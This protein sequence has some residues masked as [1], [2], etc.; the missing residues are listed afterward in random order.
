MPGSWRSLAL[1]V[2]LSVSVG[3][4]ISCSKDPLRA[5]RNRPPQTFLVAAPV[6]TSVAVLK[7]SYRVHLYWRGEDPDGFVVG[8]LYS[9]D[10]SS[11]GAF[12]FTTKTDSIF[13]LEVNDSTQIGGGTGTNPSNSRFHTFFIRAVDNL[14]KPDPQATIFNSRLF[15]AETT[16]PIVT[17]VGPITPHPHFPNDPVTIDT[18]CEGTPFQICWRGRDP[19]GVVTRYRFDVGSFSSTLST[20]SC[21]TFNDPNTPGSVQLSSGRYTMTVSAVDNANA[22]GKASVPVVVNRDPETWF[23]DKGAPIGHYIQ[24]HLKGQQTMIVGTFAP[25]DTVPFRSTVWWEWEGEDTG[26]GCEKNCLSGWSFR[27]LPGTRDGGEPYLIGFLDV[28]SAGPPLIRFNNNDPNQ[29]SQ[30][31]FANLILDSLDAGINL[32]A[33]VASRDC[34]GRADGTPAFFEFHCNFRPQL[35]SLRVTPITADVGQGLEPC[36]LIEWFGEDFE[37]G[38]TKGA[39]VRLDATRDLTFEDYEQSTIVADRVF[40]T[41]SPSGPH[42]VIVR[43]IDRAL[44]QSENRLSVEFNLPGP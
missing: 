28:L 35:D 32:V 13:E 20:D 11:I 15:N 18:L 6:D 41:L 2:L 27:L 21:A 7:Y 4:L 19:D 25:G 33:Q 43:V 39:L 9:W 44:V 24:Y 29:M 37:D 42:S 17:F 14:G 8:F 12:R 34:S 1:V 22:V 38:F 16:S 30:A 5:D 10:D 26:G 3:F 40:R 23:K 31:G 36:Q